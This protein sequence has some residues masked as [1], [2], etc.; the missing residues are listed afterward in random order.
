MGSEGP[1]GCWGVQVPLPTLP[2]LGPYPYA[3]LVPSLPYLSSI[4]TTSSSSGVETSMTSQSS[5]A[6]IRCTVPG[7]TWKRSPG[8]TS[9]FLS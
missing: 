8:S 6:V 9:C 1:T 7:V 2:T 3:F 4:R 5:I